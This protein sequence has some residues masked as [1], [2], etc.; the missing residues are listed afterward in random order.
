[1]STDEPCH[2]QFGTSLSEWIKS[3]SNELDTDEVGLWQI[4]P[5]GREGFGLAGDDL[6]NFVRQSLLALFERGAVPLRHVRDSGH[7][8]TWQ[9]GYGTSAQEMAEAI[10]EEWIMEGRPDPDLGDLWFGLNHALDLPYV[11]NS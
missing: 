9:K 3:H 2:R 4:I 11:H 5:E 6:D 7:V 8:W 10:L 1:M